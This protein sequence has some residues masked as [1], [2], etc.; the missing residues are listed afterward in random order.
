[1]WTGHVVR[2]DKEKIVKKVVDIKMIETRVRVTPK[3]RWI[4]DVQIFYQ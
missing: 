3:Q 1:M 4:K 2:M